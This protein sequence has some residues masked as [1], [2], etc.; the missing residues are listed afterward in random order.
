MVCRR[1]IE[2]TFLYQLYVCSVA[3]KNRNK[4]QNVIFIDLFFLIF[5]PPLSCT[6]PR[7][8]GVKTLEKCEVIFFWLYMA[9]ITAN[10]SHA[11]FFSPFT[12]MMRLDMT[13]VV[14]N[15]FGWR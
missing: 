6:A 11:Q 15:A 2:Q 10:K 3:E 14:I 5:T 7:R 9:I 1:R 4:W 12:Y 8:V 13:Y